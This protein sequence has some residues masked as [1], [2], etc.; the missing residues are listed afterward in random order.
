MTTHASFGPTA[1]ELRQLL[2][3]ELSRR[4]RFGYVALLLASATMT[5]VIASLWL[6]EP[7]LPTRAQIAFLVMTVIGVS[8]SSLA[9]WVLTTR[10]ILLGRD[11]V[12]AGWMAVTFTATFV[13]GALAIG[14]TSG[15]T[16]PYAAASLGMALFAIAVVVLIRARRRLASLMN[17]RD[18]LE[19]DLKA[20]GR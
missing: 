1:P 13:V 20:S 18:A 19:R 2:E 6:T 12:V 14:L 3:A 11:S 7:A 15:G 5:V 16:S 8:W 4:S 10:R 17:R 9:V